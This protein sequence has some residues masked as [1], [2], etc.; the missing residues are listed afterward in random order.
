MSRFHVSHLRALPARTTR[1]A[2]TPENAEPILD[3]TSPFWNFPLEFSSR[4]QVYSKRNPLDRRVSF[5]PW[6]RLYLFKGRS[7]RMRKN[8]GQTAY[9]ASAGIPGQ[10]LAA[11][12]RCLS[13]V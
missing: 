1:F 11:R 10:S 12:N 2:Y 5:F 6:R 4:V 9:F 7:S 8:Q 13:L 3:R